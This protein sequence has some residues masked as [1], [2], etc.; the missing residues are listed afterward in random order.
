M[1]LG[2]ANRKNVNARGRTFTELF[3]DLFRVSDGLNHVAVRA[4]YNVQS[5]G[6]LAVN[7]GVLSAVF[8]GSCEPLRRRLRVITVSPSDFTGMSK[9]SLYCSITLGTL[10]CE[11]SLAIIQ[12][13]SRDKTVIARNTVD[14]LL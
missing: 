1:V 13:A 11:T 7:T 6:V 8:E 9:T 12:T 14:Y 4:L 3:S 2:L 10:T 5:D